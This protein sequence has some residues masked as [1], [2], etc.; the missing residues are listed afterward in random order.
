MGDILEWMDE[1]I[2]DSASDDEV[3]LQ[4]MEG[5]LRLREEGE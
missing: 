5:D 3:I 1:F 2:E 4:S